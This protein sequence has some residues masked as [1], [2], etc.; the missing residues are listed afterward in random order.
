MVHG[1]V[2][3]YSRLI[4]YLTCA[5]N[6]RADTVMESFSEAVSRYGLPSRVR[7]DKGGENVAVADYMIA[8]R[9]ANRGSF[10]SGRSVHNQRIE[11]LWRDVF[12]ACLFVYYRLFHY[13]EEVG[14]L[15]ANND[16]H[17]Y[18]LHYITF[19][20]STIVSV[21]FLMV[22]TIIHYHPHRSA[23]PTNCGLVDHTQWTSL[24]A[25]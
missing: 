3:G 11:R 15:D 12:S 10:I 2:D 22:G 16:L 6:N 21:N 1:G 18:C 8:L 17:L 4:V 9:G 25:M 5:N 23:V 14:I 24:S 13:M 19:P 7:G 20:V